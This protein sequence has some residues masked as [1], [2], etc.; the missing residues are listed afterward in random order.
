MA[1][2]FFTKGQQIYSVSLGNAQVCQYLRTCDIMVNSSHSTKGSTIHSDT[3]S[4][5]L[6]QQV[7]N[8]A[9][10]TEF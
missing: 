1:I 4:H 9:P 3:N 10:S 2:L 7:P 8:S 6:K 5:L